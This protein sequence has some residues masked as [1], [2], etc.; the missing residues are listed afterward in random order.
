MSIYKES[1]LNKIEDDLQ[2]RNQNWDMLETHLADYAS[3]I[4]GLSKFKILATGNNANT[5][6]ESLQVDRGLYAVLVGG[7]AFGSTTS[8]AGLYLINYWSTQVYAVTSIS[9]NSL[10]EISI[11]SNGGLTATGRGT[12]VIIQL[13]RA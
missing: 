7:S 11:D 9:E 6:T 8:R 12:L 4:A 3:L 1:M 2:G 13:Y 10:W 5:Y